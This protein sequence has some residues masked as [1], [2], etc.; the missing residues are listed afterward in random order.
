MIIVDT[1]VV[2]EAM[3]PVA[4]MQVAAWLRGQPID[5][6]HITAITKAELLYGL[7]LMA[8]GERKKSLA[9]TIQVFLA[10]RIVNPV[11]GFTEGDALSYARISAHRRRIG[12]PIKELD[13]QI[14]AIALSQGFA[15]A[16]R[17]VRDFESCGVEIINPWDATAT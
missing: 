9:Q 10:E 5:R 2:S 12:R 11:L 16:T 14:A 8:D 15:V 4:D 7:A 17:N 13:G 3:K 1:N 6:L